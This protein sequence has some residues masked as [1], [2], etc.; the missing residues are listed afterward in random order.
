MEPSASSSLMQ[1]TEDEEGVSDAETLPGPI[2]DDTRFFPFHPPP[3]NEEQFYNKYF[4]CCMFC[5]VFMP[6][7]VPQRENCPSCLVGRMDRLCIAMQQKVHCVEIREHIMW[8]CLP[9]EDRFRES[10]KYVLRII[11]CQPMSPFRFL[12]I[13]PRPYAFQFEWEW[14]FDVDMNDDIYQPPSILAH[15]MTFLVK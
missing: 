5:R 13:S 14:T 15:I 1:G 2:V 4:V 3:Y 8:Y 10:R 12:W 7:T 11:L 6:R 9:T